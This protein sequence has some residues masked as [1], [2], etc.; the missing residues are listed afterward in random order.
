V[1]RIVRAAR[2]AHPFAAW[3]VVALVFVQVVVAAL[4]WSIARQGGEAKRLENRV[5]V[6]S[7]RAR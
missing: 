1:K 5:V 7:S 4:A 3:L 6:Q 2:F